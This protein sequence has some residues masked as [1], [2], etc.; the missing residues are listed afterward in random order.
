[1]DEPRRTG[2]SAGAPV[3][4][5]PDRL[6]ALHGVVGRVGRGRP[7][8]HRADQRVVEV[9]EQRVEPARGGDAVRVDEGD[10]GV[11]D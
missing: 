3:E 9:A 1:M 4:R 5:G 10:Q 8:G 7:G 2:P 6:V 11:C